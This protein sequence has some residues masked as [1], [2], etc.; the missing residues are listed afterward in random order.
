VSRAEKN[1]QALI[2]HLRVST[3]NAGYSC[4]IAACEPLVRMGHI[5]MSSPT[6]I[7]EASVTR[8]R[9][10]SA[11]KRTDRYAL[12]LGSGQDDVHIR[13]KAACASAPPS[14]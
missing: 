12:E 13:R 1:V 7:A 3:E 9:G 8:H 14:S 4:E 6:T 5:M 10:V 2:L 11:T